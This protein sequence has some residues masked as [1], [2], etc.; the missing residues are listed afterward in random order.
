MTSDKRFGLLRR[1]LRA[2]GLSQDAVDDVVNWIADLLAGRG[3]ATTAQAPEFPYQLRDHFLTPAEL[4][5][6]TV[7]KTA[8]GE[9]AALSTKVGL[10]D[11]FW[12]KTEDQSRFRIYTNRIDRKHVDFLVCD[13]VTMQPRVGIELD[14]R[15]HQRADRQ[16]RDEFVDQVFKAAKLPI[17]HVPAKRAYVAAEI[18]AQLAPYLGATPQPVTIQQSVA[19]EM[20]TAPTSASG[21]PT[22]PK[23]GSQMVLRTAKSGANV[24][25]RFWGCSNFPNCRSMLPY[26]E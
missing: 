14:D 19:D 12:V 11:L 20:R 18:A 24:G 4:S 7:L 13:P 8:V 15:S 5:F 6:F 21:V 1:L 22:C 9:R 26:K 25:N 10:N 2:L 17:L 3:E 16:A 23:C